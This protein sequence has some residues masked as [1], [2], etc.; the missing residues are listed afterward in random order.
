[1]AT[2]DNMARTMTIPTIIQSSFLIVL[3]DNFLISPNQRNEVRLKVDQKSLKK[4]AL[5]GVPK[6]I[7]I[8]GL[9]TVEDPIFP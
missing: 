5:P 6:K 1:M 7:S 3:T 2:A 4:K 8:I 9:S